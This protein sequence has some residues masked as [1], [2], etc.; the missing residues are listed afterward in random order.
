MPRKEIL[1]KMTPEGYFESY[2]LANP[3]SQFINSMY[4]GSTSTSRADFVDEIVRSLGDAGREEKIASD[5]LVSLDNVRKSVIREIAD[6]TINY[7]SDNSVLA[8][9]VEDLREGFIEGILKENPSDNPFVELTEAVISPS[10]LADMIVTVPK[11]AAIENIKQSFNIQKIEQV[12]SILARLKQAGNREEY[13]L[14]LNL[15]ML[16]GAFFDMYDI[17]KM[18]SDKVDTAAEMLLNTGGAVQAGAEFVTDEDFMIQDEEEGQTLEDICN[19]MDNILDYVADSF[20][21]RHYDDL[22]W[23]LIE[24][25]VSKLNN[26]TLKDID[27]V[28]M[29]YQGDVNKPHFFTAIAPIIVKGKGFMSNDLRANV[30]LLYLSAAYAELLNKGVAPNPQQILA[31][32]S[33]MARIPVACSDFKVNLTDLLRLDVL[34]LKTRLFTYANAR[35]RRDLT[36]LDFITKCVTFTRGKCMISPENFRQVPVISHAIVDKILS[37]ARVDR[38]DEGKIGHIVSAVTMFLSSART[39]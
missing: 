19:K 16:A 6:R 37:D 18:L 17:L 13:S 24:G 2:R 20:E 14:I 39:K 38:R 10:N 25:V 30:V 1:N 32:Y 22:N 31:C 15:F 23:S 26:A 11:F 36:E 28:I 7:S 33:K 29:G 27:T 9:T 4:K 8:S 3:I 35:V 5:R 34:Y 12:V 21:E